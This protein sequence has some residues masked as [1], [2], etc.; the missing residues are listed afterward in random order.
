[1][2][3]SKNILHNW[4]KKGKKCLDELVY[5]AKSIFLKK[6]LIVNCDE[7]WCNVYKYDHY[8]KCN[9]GVSNKAQKIVIFFYEN[10][11]CRHEVFISSLYVLWKQ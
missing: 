5:V 8:K 6:D 3:I 7:T 1:M 10:D 11:S 4:L 2:T 9:I